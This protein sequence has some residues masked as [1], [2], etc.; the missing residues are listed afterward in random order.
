MGGVDCKDKSV[1]HVTC[2]RATRRYWK[3]IFFNLLDM[4]LFDAY[5]LYSLNT[6]RPLEREVFMISILEALVDE[7][8]LQNNQPGPSGGDLGH[9]LARLP[10]KK[11]RLCP[12]C[13]TSEKKSRSHFWCPGCNC[14][15][16]QQC[17]HKLQHYWR[18]M[19]A[20]RK[21]THHEDA[22]DVSD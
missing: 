7:E 20:G 8:T 5:I 11:L 17:F 19:K 16:H 10:G 6:D 12:L 18:P 22:E 15:V 1:Y 3:K 13:S 2:D 4:V 14:G 9:Q 21:R